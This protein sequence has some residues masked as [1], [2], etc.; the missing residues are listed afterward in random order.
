[1][2]F[3]TRAEVLLGVCEEVVRAGADEV[4]AAD[5]GRAEVQVGGFGVRVW[6]HK[7]VCDLLAG[8]LERAA[9]MGLHTA[10]ELLEQLA[11]FSRHLR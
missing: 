2:E 1:M 10:H 6:A 11:L 7:L 8:G 3:R 4:G 9:E 5:L